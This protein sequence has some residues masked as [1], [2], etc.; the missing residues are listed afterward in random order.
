MTEGGEL[1]TRTCEVCP[2]GTFRGPSRCTISSGWAGGSCRF[3]RS[4]AS[5][6]FRSKLGHEWRWNHAHGQDDA[7]RNDHE[8]IKVAEH[9]DEVRDQ[10]DRAQRIGGDGSCHRFRV[11][12]NARISRREP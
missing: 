4:F 2:V 7:S 9:W 1:S 12:R 6:R 11:P 10:V 5:R 3:R 8:I